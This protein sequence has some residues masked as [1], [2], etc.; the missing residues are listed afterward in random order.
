ME[1]KSIVKYFTKGAL[2]LILVISMLVPM[3]VVSAHASGGNISPYILNKSTRI[4]KQ[5][6]GE[7][8]VLLKNDDN[9]LPLKNKKVNVFGAV[10][11]ALFLGGGGSGSVVTKDPIDFYEALEGAGIEYNKDLYRKYKAWADVNA[12]KPTGS[13]FIDMLTPMIRGSVMKEM[14]I[15][16]IS[17]SVMKNALNYSDTAIIVIG[18]G[19]SEMN[20]LKIEDLKLNDAEVK[21]VEKVASTFPNVIVL[22]NN[23]NVMEMGWLENYPSIKAAA[24]VWAPGEVGAESIGKMLTGEINP[25]GRLNDTIAYNISDHPSTNNFGEYKYTGTGIDS[26][27]FVNYSE[28]IYVGYRY[29][30]TFAPEKVQYPFGYGLSYTNFDW[31]VTDYKTSKD[32]ISV[33]VKVT[34]KGNYKGKD[35][36]ELYFSAPYYEGGIEKSAIELAGYAKTKLIEPGK[37]DT[38]TITYNVNDMASYDYKNEEAWVLDKGEYQIKLGRSVKDIVKTFKYNVSSKKII[39]NDSHTGTEIKNLFDDANGGLN[40][41]SRIGSMDEWLST[42]I[43]YAA[44]ESVLNSDALPEVTETGSAPK[45]GVKYDS[46]TIMLADVAK[47]KSLWDKFLDQLTV[48]EMSNLLG[49]CAYQTGALKRLG[50]PATVDNDGPASVKG[51]GGWFYTDSG[52]AYPCATTL[53]CTW[54][55]ELAEQLGVMCGEEANDIG[56]NIWYSPACNIH[57]NPCAGR[58][59]EYFSEDPLVSGKMAAA[60]TRG[61]QS[62]NVVVTVKHFALNEQETHRMDNGLYTWSNEQAMRELYFKPFEIAVKEAQALGIMSSMN[63]IGANWSGANKALLTDLLR[64]EWG[65]KGFVVSDICYNLT[66]SG[67]ADPVIALYAQNDIMLSQIWKLTYAVQH[68]SIMSAYNRDPIGFGTALRRNVKNLLIIKMFTLGFDGYD[69]I[70][71]I[72]PASFLSA[73]AESIKGIDNNETSASNNTNTEITDNQTPKASTIGDSKTPKSS[74]VPFTGQRLSSIL[75]PAILVATSSVALPIAYNI[76]KGRKVNS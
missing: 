56:T 29:F 44:P 6:E 1:K 47:D 55:D 41:L 32:K 57:R 73:S 25:S 72:Y 16:T 2:A 62:K 38:V 14:P 18:R 64:T 52:I 19:G 65:Y 26:R 35:V 31:Y 60:I 20:D 10:S 70:S 4:A 27:Y 36:V 3:F 50:I 59:F 7:G 71:D 28:G 11:G 66:G 49:D 61:A 24:M 21:M 8:I 46:G 23:G 9:A 42:P 68:T 75:L 17:S 15:S 53:S 40:F 51:E 45:T 37:S 48:T 67:Y 5:I 30:E 13:G 63:R 12:F 54:N 34:N 74:E 76:R 43:N 39:K 22:F 69:E 33:T 58:N